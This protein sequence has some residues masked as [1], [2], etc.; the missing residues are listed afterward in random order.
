MLWSIKNVS[1]AVRVL[2]VL[3]LLGPAAAVATPIDRDT[4]NAY[5]AKCIESRDERM[6]AETQEELCACTSVHLMNTLSVED[7]QVMA[8]NTPRGRIMLNKMLVE[9][10]GPCM[11]GPVR[12]LVNTQCDSD[13]RIALADQTIDRRALCGCMAEQ[14]GQWFAADGRDIMVQV[15]RD[16]PFT[17]DP[18]TPV[19]ESKTFRDQSYNAMMSCAEALQSGRGR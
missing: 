15:L 7:V 6:S 10:Y 16:E 18:I 12:D 2:F 5:F 3:L 8:E 9:V 19:M 4:A 11:A 17:S 14:T 13:P 1:R